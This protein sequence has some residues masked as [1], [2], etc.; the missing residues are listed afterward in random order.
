MDVETW[1]GPNTIPW[2]LM[3]GCLHELTNSRGA[4]SYATTCTC[5]K[6]LSLKMVKGDAQN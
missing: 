2:L 4:L 3:C 5:M 6:H 1:G